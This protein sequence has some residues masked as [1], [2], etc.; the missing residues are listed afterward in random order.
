MTYVRDNSDDSSWPEVTIIRSTPTPNILDDQP[1]AQA[2]DLSC[3]HFV[4]NTYGTPEW[5]ERFVGEKIRC[6]HCGG[7][8]DRH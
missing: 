2:L 8:H 5:P 7:Q 3:G 6:R 4:I 1:A